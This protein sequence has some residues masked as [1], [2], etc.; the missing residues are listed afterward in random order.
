[1]CNAAGVLLVFLPPY[2]PD[3]N[4]I[5]ESFA[6]LKAWIKKNRQLLDDC[7]TFEEFLILGLNYMSNKAGNHFRRAHIVNY[8]PNR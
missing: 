5:E 6:E 1:M 2:S 4:P 3:F 8:P 7:E